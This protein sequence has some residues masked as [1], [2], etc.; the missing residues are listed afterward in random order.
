MSDRIADIWG[1]RT[2][3]GPREEWPVRVDQYLLP[4]T[5]AAEV[6][7]VQSACVMC[8]NGCGMDI[9]V[10]DGRI[11]GVRGRAD[12]R[13]NHGRLGP[14][15]LFGW[16]ANGSADRLTT[17]LVREAGQLRPATWDEAMTRVVEH[18]RAVLDEHGPLGMGFYNSGQLFTEDY[19]TL[20]MVVRGGI[21]TPAPT[22]TASAPVTA[23]APPTVSASHVTESES[24]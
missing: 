3:H 18:T 5:D 11:V 17:P 4:D 6:D 7:W 14:K 1:P 21:G 24:R 22:T 20:A 10:A 12:D 19:Y 23:G 2:P 15:G 13:V 16:Q 9:A 8:S